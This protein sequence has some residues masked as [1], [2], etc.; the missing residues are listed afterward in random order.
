MAEE[1]IAYKATEVDSL[2][3]LERSCERDEAVH[4]TNVTAMKR[5]MDEGVKVTAVTYKKVSNFDMGHITIVQYK[6]EVEKQSL[7]A[8]HQTQGE[9]FICEGGAFVQSNPV[10]VLVFREKPTP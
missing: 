3:T 7:K 6:D 2:A 10:E 1:T 4:K 9:T 8:I 5:A